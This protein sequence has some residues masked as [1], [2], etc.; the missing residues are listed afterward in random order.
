MSNINKRTSYVLNLLKELKTIYQDLKHLS[1]DIENY[2]DTFFESLFESSKGEIQSDIASYK[3]NIEKM[4]E[5]NLNITT[6]INEWYDF[7]KDTNE[8]RKVSFPIKLYLK[9]K[10]FKKAITKMNSE[11]SD[12]SIENRFIREKIINWEQ[13]LSVR[14]LQ[15]IKKGNEF[16]NYE[17]LI[18][19]KDYI[20]NS[21]KYLLPTIP[22][23]G[24]IEFDLENIDTFIDKISKIAAA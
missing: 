22:D 9:K 15:E 19:K 24:S 3:S 23:I 20:I 13:E 4:K 2:S 21:L 10:N 17:N 6:K 7:I 12:L 11:I 14:A 8:I 16:H 1:S 5:L 18:K